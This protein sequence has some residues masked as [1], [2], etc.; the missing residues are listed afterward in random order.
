MRLVLKQKDGETKEFQ[1]ADRS[2]P[3]RPSRRQSRLPVRP[4]RF[5]EARVDCL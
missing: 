3:D 2:H 5:Q 4:D 1:F